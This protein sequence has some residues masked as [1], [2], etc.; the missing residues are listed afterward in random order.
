[1]RTIDLKLPKR[2]YFIGIGGISMS[3][4]ARVLKDRGFLVR[5][6]D[7]R[8]SA[9]TKALEAEGIQV[10]IGQESEHITEDIDYAVYTAAIH[11]DNP[12][13]R[14]CVEKKIPLVSRAQLLADIM[15]GYKVGIGVSGTH[16]KTTTTSMLAGIF[17]KAKLDPTI[18]VGGMLDAIGGNIRIGQGDIFLTEACEYT[19]SFLTLHPFMGIL[20]NIEEDHMDFFK[21]LADI[22]NSFREFVQN[23]SQKGYII[24]NHKIENKA[25]ILGNFSGRVLTFGGEGADVYAA[26]IEYDSMGHPRFDLM[27]FGKKWETICLQVG[28][29]HNIQNSLAAAAASYVLGV[30]GA[31]LKEGLEEFTGARRRFEHKGVVRGITI[32]DD[33]AH[34]PSE[35]GA[36][37]DI[38]KRYPHKRLV[39]V[40]Q[41]HTYSR[42]KAFFADFAK[43]LKEAELCVLAPI[44]GA[45]ETEDFGMSSEGLCREI[46]SLGGRAICPGGFDEIE[47]Y[48]LEHLEEG[49]LC[50]TM[51][52][53]DIFKVGEV[54]SGR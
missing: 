14:A 40:F 52:A 13:Y 10:D 36:T 21:N 44:Y 4:L 45:R 47:N 5:G 22:R 35:I 3:G 6:S 8:V 27:V 25:E 11:S 41:P 51:G 12:E 7:A 17:L 20:L 48:L 33:Y 2:I 46:N 34:H 29:D 31:A 32:V 1:M 39:V 24:I 38:A 16:G 50:I 28:G 37:L 26:N 49:D 42:T 18:S 43:V 23:T 9:V 30:E 19:N 53:G 54:L 15:E